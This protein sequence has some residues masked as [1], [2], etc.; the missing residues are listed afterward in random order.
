MVG[1]ME[2][3][4][5]PF[6]D[7]FAVAF[8]KAVDPH[9]W[10]RNLANGDWPEVLVAPTGSGKTA[11][12][13]LGWVFHRLRAPERTP[14]RLV[15]C[16]PMR[17]LVEQTE[18]EI[19]G[20]LTRIHHDAGF[21]GP[22]DFIPHPDDL[23]IL[24]GGSDPS[25]WLDAPERPA[26]IVGTQDMLL[27]R[28]LMRGYASSRAIW[29][30]EFAVLHEDAQWVFDEVQ[31]MGAGR[32]TSAQLEAFRRNE[33]EESMQQSLRT[34]G[35]RSR[36][37]WISAT[38][39]PEWLE[40]VDHPAP[41]P[42]K[43]MR[44]DPEMAADNRLLELARAP[45]HLHRIGDAPVSGTVN[46]EKA[47]LSQLAQA[48][49]NKHRPGHMTLVIVNQVKRAQILYAQVSELLKKGKDDDTELALIH[50]RFRPADRERE[51]AKVAGPGAESDIVVIATQAVEAGV[52]ISAA[53]MF[54]E[55]AAWSSLVQR[56]GRANRRAEV[57]GGARV[58][59]VDL[60]G[61]LEGDAKKVEKQATTV[62]LP[63]EREELHEARERLVTLNDAASVHLPATTDIGPSLRVVRRKDLDDLF[64]TDPDLTGFDVDISPYVRDADDTDIRVF[65]RDLSAS[66]DDVIKP[67]RRELCAVPIGAARNWAKKAKNLA[68]K[69]RH[70]PVFFGAGSSM[71]T[72]TRAGRQRASRVDAV[73]GRSM[74]GYDAAG[75]CAGGRISGRYRLYRSP[76][77]RANGSART[78]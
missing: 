26:V 33:F 17:T 51:M 71:A 2:S 14:R 27:S 76:E 19:R 5:P 15:W 48:V 1:G 22:R 70:G 38:L 16:L 55:L 13:T 53:V 78:G 18:H 73:P 21:S 43:V 24:M 31:L 74:A 66:N 47:Y 41:E 34:K 60:F 64:D 29:P 25:G 11:G 4:W 32:A 58:F 6:D 52:D 72:P 9:Q 65:W 40:T 63:Y 46:D 35:R 42:T 75:R 50:S 44:V 7:F 69:K 36:S 37:L 8:G 30:M 20:W 62:A 49:V 68:K 56:F 3:E 67:S 77:G 45:K 39:Q 54:T 61:R 57:E 23:H 12:V 10:Q 28:A 59:W